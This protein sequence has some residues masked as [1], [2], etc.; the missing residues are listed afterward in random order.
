MCVVLHTHAHTQIHDVCADI[1]TIHNVLYINQ[2]TYNKQGQFSQS[3]HA[4]TKPTNGAMCILCGC[5]CVCVLCCAYVCMYVCVCLCM[6]V[7]YVCSCVYIYMYIYIH[8][9]IYI[10]II[11]IHTHT[12]THTH[13]CIH[14]YKQTYTGKR[15]QLIARRKAPVAAVRR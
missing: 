14:T 11:F 15:P 5:V 1:C 12:H 2:S 7:L 10:Y 6:Y 8:I 9:Y 4:V 3:P 13:T